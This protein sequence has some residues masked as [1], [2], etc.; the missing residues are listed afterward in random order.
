MLLI[1]QYRCAKWGV[2]VRGNKGYTCRNRDLPRCFSLPVSDSAVMNSNRT[3]LTASV[4]KTMP[5]RYGV[6]LR[7]VGWIG[8]FLVAFWAMSAW[9]AGGNV[10]NDFTQNVWLPSRLV[11]DGADPY[12]PTSAQVTSALG[13][14][15][16]QFELFNSG[17]NFFFIYPTW[18]AL[19]FTPFAML[20][21]TVALAL[22][23]ALNLVLLLW[24]VVHLLRVSSPAFRS[25]RAQVF[26]AIGLTAFLS[27]IYRESLLTL[28]LGQFS[29]I[30]L[31]ILAAIWGYLIEEGRSGNRSA[32]R[33]A[34]VGVGLAV[35]STK[36]QSVGLVV[37]LIGLWALSRKRWEI[38]A[39]GAGSLATLLL[40]PMIFY[41]SSLGGWLHRVVGGQAGS[42]MEVSASVWGIS[43]DWLGAS[44][45]WMAVAAVLSLVG[46]A[47][48]IPHWK[49]D[50]LV[51][52]TSPVPMSLSIT[53]VINSVISPYLLGYEHV[54]L[55]FPAML[56]LAAAGVPDEQPERG[57]KMWR[58]A[59]YGWMA[60]LPFIVVALQV[61]L[62]SK[63][64]PVA[65]QAFTMLALL[66]A[67]K[68]KWGK[69]R[70]P[71]P[72]ANAA[73]AT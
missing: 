8:L 50:L 68:L 34:L 1:A 49:H 62:D 12:N 64:Y 42:Q 72:T 30:E 3:P 29:F 22:W 31:G 4:D 56:M 67:A 9:G 45:P 2:S 18:V 11:L 60:A 6:L 27:V 25:G 73:S 20:P 55:L 33:T 28:Y 51:D 52:R 17:K 24:S 40:A 23:R 54:L 46:L 43:Y 13:D 10:D 35:L 70:E 66:Y 41:P 44:M 53:L 69:E 5:A 58:I 14:Y 32:W 38:P 47:A 19:V 61:G 59:I 71:L 7:V 21:I 26:A 57:W 15:A 39:W 37:V 48:L 65:V 63:E 16:S 36:P